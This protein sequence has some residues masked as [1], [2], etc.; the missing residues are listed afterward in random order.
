WLIFTV[1]ALPDGDAQP[2]RL[3]PNGRYTH[4]GAY[5]HS[6]LAD[7]GFGQVELRAEVLRQEA[8]LPVAGWLVTARSA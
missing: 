7:A 5:L 3:H 8:T 4:A 2:H 6:T 1:E